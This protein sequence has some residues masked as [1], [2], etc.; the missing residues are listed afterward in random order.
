MSNYNHQWGAQQF[1]PN[2]NPGP[3]SSRGPNEQSGYGQNAYGQG[4]YGQTGYGQGNFGHGNFG[5]GA[6]THQAGYGPGAGPQG[7]YGGPGRIDALDVL[8]GMLR[9][10]FSLSNFTRIARA[11]GS[12]F[13][14]GAAIGAGAV[15]LLNRPDVRNAFSSAFHKAKDTPQ[16]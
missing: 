5:Q 7:P 9:D 4:G 11:S 13:W 1:G 16:E 6:H 14:I 10:G 15:V 2:G 12:N 3:G 8:E